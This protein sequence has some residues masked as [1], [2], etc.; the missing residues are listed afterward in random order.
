MKQFFKFMFASM[1]A[2]LVTFF[3][4]MI[5]FVAIIGTVI[6]SATS[7]SEKVVDVKDN[8]VLHLKFDYQIKDRT[9]N[10]PFENFDFSTFETQDNLG[11]DKILTNIEKAK[12]DVR[13]KGIYLD[14]TSLNTGIAT[15][16]E[17]HHALKDFKKSGKWIISYSEVYTQSTYY[18][19]SLS[20]KIYLNPAG[21]VEMRGLSTE[22]MFFK[23]ALEKLDVEMQIIRHG[24]F[25]SAVEP[26]I[27]EKMSD[28]NREQMNL[29]L[30]SAW[31]SILNDISE[32]RKISIEELNAIA[33]DIKIQT[34]A[35]A[36]KYGFVDKALYKD[37]VLEELKTR[38]GASSYDDIN[39]ISLRKYDNAKVTPN[40]SKNEIAIIYASGEINSGK[41]RDDVMGSE[42]ISQ[43][44]REARLDD[45]V[46]AIV[47]RVNS[48][49]GS[50]LASDVMWREVVLAK[51]VKPVVVSMGDVAASGGYYIACAA[52]KIVAD[53]KTITGSI[54][55]FGVVPN[56]QGFF[57]NKLGITFDVAKTNKHADIMTMFK[58]L[59]AEEKDII[60]I[61]VE[62]IY[63]DFIGKV[64]EGRGMT[65]EQVDSIGQG[66]VWLALDA[67]KIGLVD[68]IG[69]IDKAISIAKELAKITDYKTVDFPKMKD[70]FE[71]LMLEITGE[72]ESKILKAYMGENYKYYQKIQTMTTQSGYMARMPYEIDFH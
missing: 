38:T 49:G 25:K 14:L 16:E 11:L 50:A 45:K 48:P 35:D 52:N 66:R 2:M 23:N 28:S 58:P 19:A 61:G 51:K 20:D 47:L 33:D 1:L 64:A 13:I 29:I 36:I 43:A 56:A 70:P 72:A 62:K 21:L 68:E 53:E 18:L 42:T 10:N 60:Q 55:V 71:Q 31:G 17:I 46:K 5:I 67:K 8:S 30:S 69:G 57:N 9:S 12:S 3:I 37:E 26:Y 63:D 7:T 22:L 34:A 6:S 40:N 24:K 44:I 41:S 32:S 4:T 65:K 54:G 15:L 39:Y 59:T 27:L